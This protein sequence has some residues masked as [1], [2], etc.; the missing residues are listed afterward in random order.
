MEVRP[1]SFKEVEGFVN[2]NLEKLTDENDVPYAVLKVKTENINDRQRQEL[3]FEGDAATSVECEYKIGEVWV[4]L[5]YKASYLKISHP[6]LSSTEFYFPCEMKPKSGY[7][8]T[9]VNNAVQTTQRSGSLVIKTKPELGTVIELNGTNLPA[10][11]YEIV[12]TQNNNSTRVPVEIADSETKVVE[13]E[14]PNTYRRYY[15]IIIKTDGSGNEDMVYVD[16]VYV[17]CSPVRQTLSGGNHNIKF[18]R[19]TPD[20]YAV[21]EKQITINMGEK[22]VYYFDLKKK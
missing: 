20:G 8:I 2:I 13:V 21:V 17:G 19:K 10:G 3:F 4:Y 14:I 1:G 15:N 22:N 18:K 9:L 11:S 6:D 12:I 5:T 16:D 7:E